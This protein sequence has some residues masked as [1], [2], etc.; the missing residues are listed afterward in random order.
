MGE[1]ALVQFVGPRVR[2]DSGRVIARLFVPGEELPEG[3][4]RGR[5]VIDRVLGLDDDAVAVS[6]ADITARFSGRHRHLRDILRENFTIATHGRTDL[7]GLRDDRRLLIGAY[8]TMEYAVES[9]AVCNPSMVAHPDQRNLAPG[10]VRFVMSVRA[11]GEGH[12]S[13]VEF[14]TGTVG[15]DR[16]LTLDPPSRYLAPGTH[17]PATYERVLFLARLVDLDADAETVSRVIDALPDRFDASTLRRAVAALHPQLSNRHAGHLAVEQINRVAAAEYTMAF[18]PE[19]SISERL[20]W[21]ACASESHGMEDVRLVRFSDDAGRATYHGTYTAYDGEHIV[22]RLLTTTDFAT[23][24][25]GQLAGPAAQDKGMA[26]FPRKVGGR[27]LALSRWDRE[28]VSLGTSDDGRVWHRSA[29][30]HTPREGWQLVQVGNCG[31]PIETDA[32]WLVLTHGVG[33]MRTYS[34]GAVLLDRDDPARVLAVLEEPLLSGAGAG[35]RDGY[36]PNVVY[37]C[38]ALR[39]GETLTIPYGIGDSTIG[40]AQVGLPALLRQMRPT[41]VERSG[42]SGQL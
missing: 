39:H 5:T 27:Y 13:S 23:F 24:T 29:T 34:I 26:L 32:G 42:L 6:I 25:S 21:P 30:L 41:G 31:S 8:F 19:T 35:E 3:A 15:P 16:A 20:L 1:R 36:V 9:A 11:V 10:Q 14:R 40:F 22:P 12:R 37:S 33:A 17:Q 4:S 38:G 28:N 2:P 18:P 7:A